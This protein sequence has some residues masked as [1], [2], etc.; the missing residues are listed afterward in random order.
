MDNLE[1]KCEDLKKNGVSQRLK[2]KLENHKQLEKYNPKNQQTIVIKHEKNIKLINQIKPNQNKSKNM[3]RKPGNAKSISFK[4]KE[5]KENLE[6]NLSMYLDS[7]QDAIDIINNNISKR[8]SGGKVRF[9]NENRDEIE[10]ALCKINKTILLFAQSHSNIFK[11]LEEEKMNNKLLEKCIDEREKLDDKFKKLETNLINR[12]N[13]NLESM[14]VEYLR[15]H[16]NINLNEENT[17]KTKI[18]LKNKIGE[19]IENSLNNSE[20]EDNFIIPRNKRLSKKNSY[21]NI[22]K[23]NLENNNEINKDSTNERKGWQTPPQKNGII[24]TLN[25]ENNQEE[26]ENNGKKI[27]KKVKDILIEKGIEIQMKKVLK[28][29]NGK[30]IIET[31]NIKEDKLVREA[32]KSNEFLNIKNESKKNHNKS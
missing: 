31:K 16:V 1:K 9:I 21:A 14:K 18:L 7:F 11:K 3:D 17:L 28:T 15:N 20:E 22:T 8:D 23:K 30:I 24:I 27:I 29:K 5:L 25:N 4:E 32:I 2:E 12:M 6:I 19:E 10:K 13:E 26:K